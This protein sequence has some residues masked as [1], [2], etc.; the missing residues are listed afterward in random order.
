VGGAKLA[1]GLA[2]VLPP[3]RLTLVVNTGDDE[4]LFGLH[5]APDLDT[6]MYTLAGVVNPATGWGV[7]DETFHSLEMLGRYGAPIW[8]RLGDRD[9]ATHVLRRQRLDEGRSLSEVTEELCHRLGVRH[10]IVPMSDHLVRTVVETDEGDLA[11][12]SYFVERRC[13]PRVRRLRFEGAAEALPAPQVT[14]ALHLASTLIFCPSNPWLS[15]DPILAVPGIREAVRD[16]RGRRLAVSPIVGGK[17]LKGPAAK[18]M[19]ELG[20]DVGTVGIA[21]YYRGLCDTLVIDAIDRGDVPAIEARGMSAYSTGTV[22][23]TAEEKVALA[24]ELLRI[25]DAG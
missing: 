20:Y 14:R 7:E 3:D 10:P 19:S 2:A 9:L 12:Q 5:V 8:F 18:I 11:F 22:M 23:R 6:V 1:L 24:R 15:I 21:D 16:F 17:A 25:A 4:G 13:E